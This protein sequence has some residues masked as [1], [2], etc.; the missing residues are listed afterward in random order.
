M[1]K[2]R[3][4]VIVDER[5]HGRFAGAFPTLEGAKYMVKNNGLS[6]EVITPEEY[7]KRYHQKLN[8]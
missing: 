7:E 2:D 6:Q 1:A 5:Y 8:Y 4:Y 3:H